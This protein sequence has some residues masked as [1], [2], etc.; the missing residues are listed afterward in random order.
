MKLQVISVL[1]ATGVGVGI[2]VSFEFKKFFDDLFDAVGVSKK[3]PTRTANDKFFNR[4]IIASAVLSIALL[5]MFVVSV[6]SSINR[7]RSRGGFR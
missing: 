1:L 7:G 6:I 3:D 5:A 4:G 2:A